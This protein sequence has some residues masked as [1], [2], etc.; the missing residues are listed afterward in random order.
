M[1]WSL[2]LIL[3]LMGAAGGFAAGLLGIGG[4]MVLVPFITM[5]FTAKHFPPELVVHMAIATSLA[6]ILF[7]SMSSVRAHHA[8]GAVNW[9]IVRLLAPGILL[10]SWLG[11]WIG[12]QMDASSL[13]LFFGLFVAFSA[14]QMLMSKKS[15]GGRALPGAPGM[16][17]AG[18][19][20]GVLAGLVG[21][22]GGFISVPF[23]GWCNVK[24][25]NAV[26]T[27]AALGFPIALAGTLSNIYF[28]AGTAG[29]PA[30]SLGFIYLPALLVIAAASVT[31]APLGAR[32]AH[33][34][35]VQALKKGFAGIL[36]CLAA[37]MLWKA[38]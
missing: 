21:A 26:A 32:T 28:G 10:G 33:R 22:G 18:G 36:Y 3:L 16:F 7:T 4:G 31:M 12:K 15:G 1:D 38:R 34:L 24:I 14:T 20:I 5:I 8:K 11:P 30:Y 2:V 25:H 6:T 9:R 27:S 19:V 35:P 13:A 37:Y 29:L 17:A 23:M